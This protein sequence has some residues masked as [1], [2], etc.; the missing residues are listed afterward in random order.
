M[1][2]EFDDAKDATNVAKHGVSLA[3]GAGV[4]ENR[5]GEVMDDRR[6]SG[7]PAGATEMAIVKVTRAGA[8]SA[9]H[10]VDWIAQDAKTDTDIAREVASNPDAAPLLDDVQTAAGLVRLIRQRL[11]ISQAEFATRF[12]VPLGT[13]RDWEQ[14]R[15]QPDTTAL[16]YLRVIAKEPALVA[17]ALTAA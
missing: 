14:G 6:D 12:H 2:I 17:R 5:I 16:T 4:L 10:K 7:E 8:E 13:L 1:D 9:A 15:K 3:L 11:G